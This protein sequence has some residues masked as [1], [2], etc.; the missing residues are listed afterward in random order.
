M[1]LLE[2]RIK[3]AKKPIRKTLQTTD[4]ASVVNSGSAQRASIILSPTQQ[5][6]DSCHDSEENVLEE[7][8]VI[9]GVT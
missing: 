2:E 9:P 5:E 4:F 1:S 3:R 8:D 6:S 7:D